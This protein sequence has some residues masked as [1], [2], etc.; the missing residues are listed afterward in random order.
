MGS[1]RASSNSVTRVRTKAAVPVRQSGLWLTV[2][3]ILW[4]IVALTS[5]GIFI[6]AVPLF[7][8]EQTTLSA[9]AFPLEWPRGEI[10]AV[11]TELDL[12]PNAVAELIITTDAI[13]FLIFTAV[14]FLIFL[15]KSDEW[16]GWFSSL[17]LVLFGWVNS[18][19]VITWANSQA[20]VALAFDVINNL[21]WSGF[22]IFLYIFPDGRFVPRWTRFLVLVALVWTIGKI[23]LPLPAWDE[24]FGLILNLTIFGVG[25]FGQVQRYR[26]I[27]GPAQRQQTKWLVF[28]VVIIF[29]ISLIVIVILPLVFPTLN[30]IG[31]PGLFKEII[32][33][34]TIISLILL[35]VPISFAISIL[36]YR[37]WD[38]DVVI[39]RA[40][41]YG[42]LTTILA[43]I[44]AGSL[45]LMDQITE[46]I[47]GDGSTAL[48]A[49][50]STILVASIFQPLRDRVETWI[51]KRFYPEKLGL[52]KEFYEF[53]PH[54][55]GSI[56][57]SELLKVTV[58]RVSKMMQSKFGA[59]Y[60][61]GGEGEFDVAENYSLRG[62]AVP[63][64][65][66]AKEDLDRLVKAKAIL[67]PG[68]DF[69]IVVPIYVPRMKENQVIGL[70]G[71]G[72]REQE[73]GYSAD[74]MK[75]L[76]KVGAKAGKAIYAAQLNERMRRDTLEVKS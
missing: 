5:L 7:Y 12:S 74:D 66:P 26:M 51:N 35:L 42:T 69:D 47:F 11:L 59:I 29:V 58:Q 60:L 64:Y 36:R 23:F 62:E 65:A 20:E 43:A 57:T 46:D 28:S 6:N 17:L 48:T 21:V 13:S 54:I 37:L 15:K 56:N 76:A 63:T 67:Q 22:F 40:L 19:S 68:G 71:L 75:T 32:L 49:T 1:T 25:V 70:L 50:V 34:G 53:E 4:V 41:I 3:R 16:I 52:A 45:S 9:Q 31:A 33:M 14:G 73:R 24:G 55:V 44:F 8:Q 39:N 10:Q 72:P 18:Y 61:N 38:I 27:S 2:T 30:Q